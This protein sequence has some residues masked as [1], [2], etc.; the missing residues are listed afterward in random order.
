LKPDA[1]KTLLQGD[2][3]NRFLFYI[4]FGVFVCT[5]ALTGLNGSLQN[6][7]EVLYARVARETFE[8]GSVLLQYNDG[9]RWF[10]KSPMMFW[11]IMLSY[12]VFGVSDFAAKFPSAVSSIVTAFMILL[13]SMK[14][15]SSRRAGTIAAFIYLCSL[16]AYA[17]THQVATDSLLV[18]SLLTTLFFLIRGVRDRPS[19][20]FVASFLNG[21][22]FL[23]KS[24]FG[25][26][27]PMTLFIYIIIEK[28][29]D[30]FLHLLL[31]LVIS[32]GMSA[33]YFIYVYKAIPEVFI[34]S[35][36]GV[37]LLQRFHSVGSAGISGIAGIGSL[38]FRVPYNIG[39]YT[40]SIFL[41]VLPFTPAVFFLFYRKDEVS[42]VR[43]ILW[44]PE[45]RLVSIYFFVILFG[46]SLLEGHW[47]HWSLSM[48][49]AVCILLGRVLDGI[50]R[51]SI[52]L[53]I[54]GL[55]IIV[56]FILT[57][58]L[59]TLGH[60]YPVFKDVVLGLII[61]YALVIVLCILLYLFNVDPARGIYLLA[62]VFFIA[63]TVH[64]AV[65]VPL[66]F[67]PD[68]KAF[69]RIVYDE[70]SPFVVIGT[71]EVNEGNKTFA[72]KWYL[73]M[74]SIQYRTIDEFE[75]AADGIENGTYVML[76]R[77]D[78]E[79]VGGMFSSF[80]TLKKGIV[81]NLGRVIEK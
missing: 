44:N 71:D 53:F 63:F 68:L 10:H 35:F 1:F 47:L 40:V 56:A 45:S 18:A 22:L 73:K 39:Y 28:R 48:I 2:Y 55:G 20:L 62:G 65:T 5:I 79:K 26:V 16:Q 58:A 34:Q 67:N 31:L 6:L 7:D 30:L 15:F 29:W 75:N 51:R 69:G 23:T 50:R 52:F 25:F 37:N 61:V 80:E 42:R 27:M 21:L 54:G 59:I 24:V 4:V 77:G 70:S 72:T 60:T 57:Y 74:D 41:F 46:F 12:R 13:I 66:D 49:P 78:A 11:G 38:L 14:V 33:W 17:S 81:W 76:Y 32:L 43:D 9:E 3:K 8:K 19:W 64:T 36:L